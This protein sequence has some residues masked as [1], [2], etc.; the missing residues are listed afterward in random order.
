VRPRSRLPRPDQIHIRLSTIGWT[1]AGAGA[2]VGFIA[3]GFLVPLFGSLHQLARLALINGPLVV[4]YLAVS[5]VVV[6]RHFG[7]HVSRN[8]RLGSRGSSTG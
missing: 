2:L 7:R 5:G 4:A 1:A 6:T 3:I 8:P